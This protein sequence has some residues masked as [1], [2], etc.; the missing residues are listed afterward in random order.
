MTMDGLHELL[1]LLARG[2]TGSAGITGGVQHAL[3][4]F[5]RILAVELVQLSPLPLGSERRGQRL[6]W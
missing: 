5:H 6:G 1:D 3:N 4:Q 2:I